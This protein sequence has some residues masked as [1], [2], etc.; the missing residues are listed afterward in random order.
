VL[1]G[2]LRSSFAAHG[3]DLAHCYVLG[4]LASGQDLPEAVKAL[5]EDLDAEAPEAAELLWALQVDAETQQARLYPL[6]VYDTQG[7]LR[8]GVEFL[9]EVARTGRTTE[10]VVLRSVEL[11]DPAC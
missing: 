10:A 4:T 7:R 9:E 5:I 11:A 2:Q 1:L 6:V 8:Y 3:Y